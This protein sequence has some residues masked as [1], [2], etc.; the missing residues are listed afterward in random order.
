LARIGLDVD[1]VLA[2][3]NAGYIQLFN[4]LTGK[5]I[6]L[7]YMPETWFY[8][9]ALGIPKVTVDK[10]LEIIQDPE[11]GFWFSLSPLPVPNDLAGLCM[12]ED[13]Y[14]ITTRPGLDAKKQTEDWLMYQFEI[15]TPTVLISDDKGAIAR[16][17][18]LDVFI[19]DRDMNLWAVKGASPATT[20]YVLDYPYN[21][22]VDSAI[23]TR[24]GSLSE[25]I[26]DGHL[27]QAGC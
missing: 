17:L 12:R 16:G 21:R 18:K 9:E 23:A 2:D 1:G 8:E 10:A 19:D 22:S 25:V 4:S 13:V 11:S 15:G 7:D 14:F 20:C 5:D 26:C 6:P 24:I 3:F 27:V